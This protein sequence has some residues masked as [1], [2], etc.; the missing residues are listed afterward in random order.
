MA[1]IPSQTAQVL[2][3]RQVSRV[4]LTRNGNAVEALSDL[5]LDVHAGEV[6]A[7]VGPSGCGKSTLLRILA[8]LDTHYAG[9]IDWALPEDGARLRSATVF[10][11]DSTLPWMDVDKNMRVGLSG[12]RLAKEEADHRIARYL[13]L[14]GLAGFRHAYP[15]ELSGGMRQRV[16]IARALA[17][18][19]AL[20]LMDEPLAALD[21][22]TRLVIQQELLRI[23]GQT[24]STVIY[25][26][27]DIGEAVSLADRVV[28]MTARPGRIKRVL[29]I[30]FGSERDVIGLRRHPEFGVLEAEIWGLVAEE[31]GQSLGGTP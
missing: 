21:S 10:Q 19:P 24:R 20:L 6:I 28:V 18:E 8:G 27:H 13:S 14:V 5:S 26:T 7:V 31:V 12:L 9:Q 3:L 23:W 15:H 22:Q 2:C 16:A 25:I 17:T 1:D 30:P 11:S 29:D 4:H